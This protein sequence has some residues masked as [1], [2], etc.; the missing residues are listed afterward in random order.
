M[1]FDQKFR[2]DHYNEYRSLK[3]AV[4]KSMVDNLIDCLKDQG[5]R[6][7]KFSLTL[8]NQNNIPQHYEMHFEIFGISNKAN[9][10]LIVVRDVLNMSYY[11]EHDND[12]LNGMTMEM[13]DWVKS[14]YNMLIELAEN[15]HGTDIGELTDGKLGYV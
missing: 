6:G 8:I 12:I 3:L 7:T 15:H 1:T 10:K 14:R 13:K 4:A 5:L 2:D 11:I 9:I